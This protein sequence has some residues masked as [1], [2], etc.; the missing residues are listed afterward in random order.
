MLHAQTCGRQQDNYKTYIYSYAPTIHSGRWCEM[1]S[2]G[3]S[4]H[5]LITVSNNGEMSGTEQF[6][7]RG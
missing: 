7:F 6:R 1:I 2:W 3:S 5:I 4:T